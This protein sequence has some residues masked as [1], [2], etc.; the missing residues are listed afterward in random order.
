[1]TTRPVMGQ[2]QEYII[3]FTVNHPKKSEF[4]S[5]EYIVTIDD[6]C[7]TFDFTQVVNIK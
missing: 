3:M 5:N 2:K 4:F 1:M 7:I 6:V